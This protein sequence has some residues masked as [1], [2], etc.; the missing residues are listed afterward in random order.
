MFF[1]WALSMM[2]IK[3]FT[4]SSIFNPCS[5]YNFFLNFLR[6]ISLFYLNNLSWLFPINFQRIIS[7]CLIYPSVFLFSSSSYFFPSTFHVF[8]D[9]FSLNS[10]FFFDRATLHVESYFPDQESNLHTLHWKH[11][12]FHHWTTRKAL[13]NP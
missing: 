6:A 11:K 7:F 8:W 3:S 10:F 4:V 2:G 13:L 12:S 9:I 5:I 1:L